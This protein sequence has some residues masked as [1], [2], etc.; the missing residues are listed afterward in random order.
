[1][2]ALETV[3]KLMDAVN[4]KDLD[5]MMTFFD[6]ESY[7]EPMPVG[8]Q[9][10]KQAIRQLLEGML[11]MADEHNWIIHHESE[12]GGTAFNERTDIFKINGRVVSIRCTGVFDVEDGIIKAWRSYYDQA[13]FDAQLQ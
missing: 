4:H 2:T 10:G 13:Q 3:Q 8:K 7:Y 1:M 11:A 9:Q 6:E 5:A 12:Q